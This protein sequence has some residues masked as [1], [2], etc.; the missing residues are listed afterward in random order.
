MHD[1]P[2]CFYQICS[3]GNRQMCPSARHHNGLYAHRWGQAFDSVH[4]LAPCYVNFCL[5]SPPRCLRGGLPVL[6]GPVMKLSRASLLRHARTGMWCAR[7]EAHMRRCT[8]KTRARM[9]PHQV[10]PQGKCHSHVQANERS[11]QGYVKLKDQL[12]A[13]TTTNCNDA[14]NTNMYPTKSLTI[15]KSLLVDWS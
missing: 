2:L 14:G 6:T 8:Q 12:L 11:L 1:F 4:V 5:S 7:L 3:Q 13:L 9:A 15:L 10:Q